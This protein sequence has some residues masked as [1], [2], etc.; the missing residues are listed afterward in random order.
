MGDEVARRWVV[1]QPLEAARRPPRNLID[2]LQLP[3]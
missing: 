3:Q 2:G 1:E